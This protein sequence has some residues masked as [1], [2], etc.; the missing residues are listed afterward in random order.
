MMVHQLEA[1]NSITEQNGGETYFLDCTI[2][3]DVVVL[4]TRCQGFG[5]LSM[6]ISPATTT[7]CSVATQ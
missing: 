7:E 2:Y 4:I 3:V 1:F 6:L 5:P